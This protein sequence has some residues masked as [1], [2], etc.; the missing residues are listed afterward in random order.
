MALDKINVGNIANDGTGDDLRE[1]FIKVNDN[2]EDL[3]TRFD[4]ESIE[5]ENLGSAGEGIFA[6]KIDNTFRFKEILAGNNISVSS[7]ASSVIINST[8]GLDDIL[9]LTDDGSITVDGSTFLGISGGD[10]IK[11]RVNLSNLIIEVKDGALKADGAPELSAPLNAANKN[12]FDANTITAN[13]FVGPLTGLVYGVDI[14]EISPYFEDFDFGDVFPR[15]DHVIDY[16]VFT[17]DV[18]LGAFIGE[19]RVDFEIDLGNF[20]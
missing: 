12:I 2:F 15:F 19:D 1:A 5:G 18:D 8:G 3:D 6:G 11:T 16:V 20:I 13:S 14:R 17:T 4:I 10:G 9:I 7:N